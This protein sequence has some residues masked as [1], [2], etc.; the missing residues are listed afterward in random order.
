MKKLL[1]LG[2]MLAWGAA[3]AAQENG[4]QCQASA[5]PVVAETNVSTVSRDADTG[6]VVIQLDVDASI[7]NGGSPSYAFTADQGTITSEGARATWT[8]SGTGPFSANVAV[9]SP[10]TSCRAYAHFTYHMEQ[11]AT[12]SQPSG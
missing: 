10:D 9:S 12:G 11:T 3:A 2:P 1:L 6:N 5:V 7:P 4:D 8:V